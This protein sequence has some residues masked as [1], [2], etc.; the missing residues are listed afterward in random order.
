M[1]AGFV[2]YWWQG[3]VSATGTVRVKKKPGIYVW[4]YMAFLPR[5]CD[6]FFLTKML[7]D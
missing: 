6:K 2:L 4:S 5:V 7:E 1:Q 3:Q